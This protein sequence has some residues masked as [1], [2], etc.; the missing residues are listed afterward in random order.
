MIL[1]ISWK[2]IWRNKVRSL[3]VIIAIT[4]GLFGA[5]FGVAL[6]NGMILQRADEMIKNNISHIQI[7]HPEFRNNFKSEFIIPDL[8]QLEQKLDNSEIVKAYASRVKTMAMGTNSYGS[9]GVIINAIN[10]NQEK[11]VTEIYKNIVDSSGTYF[12]S[13]KKN[14]VLISS[15]LAKKLKIV[16]FEV[17]NKTIEELRKRKFSEENI[18]KLS[19]IKNE[20][21]RK[22]KDFNLKIEELIGE[23][24][25]E[26]YEKIIA[27]LSIKYKI[28]SKIIFK[29][30]NAE[31]EMIDELF[32]VV[33]VYKTTN[34]MYDQM[35]VFVKKDYFVKISKIAPNTAHEIAIILESDKDIDNKTAQIQ[36]LAPDLEVLNFFDTDPMMEMTVKWAQIYYY[37]LVIIILFALGFGIVNT[38]LMVVLERV[39]EL[40]MLMAIGMNKTKIF[41]MIML[42]SVFLSLIGGVVGMILGAVSTWQ[43]GINGWDIS[44]YSEGME[45][46]GY[47][48]IIYPSLSIDFLIGTTI[49]VILTGIISAI[50]PARKALKLN[51][52]DAIRSDA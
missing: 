16:Q 13:D 50:Y 23:E 19:T 4:I 10:P 36:T 8:D 17:T 20:L 35:N 2:N 44:Q 40:G 42:E 22:E 18:D 3:V 48:S 41:L 28:R 49:L 37:I 7:H 38:M 5:V 32:K 27:D 26:I 11:K 39:K 30:Q 52:A 46:V 43:L 15:T 9:V 24:Q 21:F 33:G 25:F 31:G 51:P 34:A 12:E 1:S 6:M 47:S 45:A 14:S 29:F